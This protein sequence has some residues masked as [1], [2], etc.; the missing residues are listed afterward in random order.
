M[1]IT[2]YLMLYIPKWYNPTLNSNS[3]KEN[4]WKLFCLFTKAWPL[5]YR[6]WFVYIAGVIISIRNLLIITVTIKYIVWQ[7]LKNTNF[8][9]KKQ[10]KTSSLKYISKHIVYK[11]YIYISTKLLSSKHWKY[12]YLVFVTLFGEKIGKFV[13]LIY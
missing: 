1:T 4:Y 10:M 7:K 3:R 11:I 13:V 2:Q 9:K 5:F 8:T 12:D 6:K